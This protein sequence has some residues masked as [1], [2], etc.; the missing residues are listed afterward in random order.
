MWASWPFPRSLGNDDDNSISLV[1]FWAT[2]T[3][4][5]R[6]V[7]HMISARLTCHLYFWIMTRSLHRGEG[8]LIERKEK[9]PNTPPPQTL[10]GRSWIFRQ[11]VCT[12]I[13]RRSWISS[14]S[15]SINTAQAGLTWELE[16]PVQISP[17]FKT[18]SDG[19]SSTI[20]FTTIPL[21]HSQQFFFSS[22][23]PPRSSM[24]AL[25][26]PHS[27]PSAQVWLLWENSPQ[28]SPIL[29][30]E[31][32][33][34]CSGHDSITSMLVHPESSRSLQTRKFSLFMHASLGSPH[35]LYGWHVEV[36]LMKCN[37]VVETSNN[38]IKVIILILT[39][40]VQRIFDWK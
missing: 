25:V 23:T 30:M 19:H 13:N 31:A 8:W 18:I 39:D 32:H 16:F 15:V 6:Q 34:N 20:Q 17:T 22:H 4:R 36:M 1:I 5:Q 37:I 14:Q 27:R 10:N 33:A 35:T 28:V 38:L 21:G 40:C 12:N 9:H 29:A 26:E 11:S 2:Y 24:S 3:W 7:L